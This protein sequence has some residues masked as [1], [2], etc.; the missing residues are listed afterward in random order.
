M[1]DATT[2]LGY[3]SAPLEN[4]IFSLIPVPQEEATTYLGGQARAPQA[5][6]DASSQIENYDEETGL[7][8]VSK[9]IHAIAPSAAPT[10]LGLETW[11]REQ[12]TQAIDAVSVPVLLGGEG[13]ITRWGVEALMEKTEEISILHID[14]HADLNSLDGGAN[15]LNTMRSLLEA[16]PNI[17]ICQ[18][19]VRSLT[20]SAFDLIVDDEKPVECIF[21]SD[22]TRISDDEE[23]NEMAIQELRSPVYLSIDLSAL[24]PSILPNVG[25]PEPGGLQWYQ[26]LRLLKKVAS[27]RRIA[28]V[29]IVELCPKEGSVVSDYTA[30]KLLYKTMNYIFSGGK[31]L[32]KPAPAGAE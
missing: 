22:I 7:N 14:A 25:N 9:G 11:V 23:W 31:M 4:S 12:V 27:R 17:H 15:N 21:M 32:E 8:L 26:L 18:V 1:S 5:I 16:H 20:Q 6:F 19:G 2:F 29:D 28:A 24:D 30:A 13:S 10:A 3:E